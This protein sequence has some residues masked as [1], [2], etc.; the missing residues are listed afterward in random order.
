M[1]PRSILEIL[2]PVSEHYIFDSTD[3][4]QQCANI[5]ALLYRYRM[6]SNPRLIIFYLTVFLDTFIPEYR[7]LFNLPG[8]RTAPSQ[9][10]LPDY[11]GK[12]E[13][14]TI[15]PLHPIQRLITRSI[16]INSGLK[17]NIVTRPTD[18][19]C[20]EDVILC[21]TTSMLGNYLHARFA[22]PTLAL[23][24]ESR[25]AIIDSGYIANLVAPYVDIAMS[26][27]CAVMIREHSYVSGDNMTWMEFCNKIKG[28]ADRFIRGIEIP[29]PRVP[30]TR[31]PTINR[32]PMKIR[33]VP[34]LMDTGNLFCYQCSECKALSAYVGDRQRGHRRMGIAVNPFNS[35]SEEAIVECIKCRAPA[36]FLQLHGQMILYRT[37][38]I[39]V[40]C[41][42]C[43]FLTAHRNTLVNTEC[44]KC[45]EK[46]IVAE[47]TRTSIC[48]FCNHKII[49]PPMK[50]LRLWKAGPTIVDSTVCNFHYNPF[51]VL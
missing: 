41:P 45:I 31:A 44:P 23:S 27:Y 36:Q 7:L 2:L 37:G 43:N 15:T 6:Q 51:V 29:L 22:D 32:V 5:S 24:I 12:D 4:V 14:I 16:R 8:T 46:K 35:F 49:G 48:Y 18:K 3:I 9:L 19:N 34:C 42:T 39:L 30:A 38:A 40:V 47:N 25:I 20:I 13:V 1:T 26:E 50:Q 28:E 21:V 10:T 33:T 17:F 11:I